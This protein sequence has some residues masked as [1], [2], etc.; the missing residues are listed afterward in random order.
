MRSLDWKHIVS[1]RIIW[2]FSLYQVKHHIV[3]KN[4]HSVLLQLMT[5][6]FSLNY[7]CFVAHERALAFNC[8]KSRKDSLEKK[9]WWVITKQTS[10]NSKIIYWLHFYCRLCNLCTPVFHLTL[11]LFCFPSQK[12][13]NI[14]SNENVTLLKGSELSVLSLNGAPLIDEF[15]ISFPPLLY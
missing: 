14:K 6:Q 13:E 15:I 5:L 7:P 9:I 3:T 8:R 11:L 12:K 1:W 10:R 4:F 2:P